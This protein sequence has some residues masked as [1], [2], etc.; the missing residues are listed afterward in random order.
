MYEL[1]VK[2]VQ[3]VG[4]GVA[5]SGVLVVMFFYFM[6]KTLKRHDD[7]VKVFTDT[8][9]AKDATLNNHLAHLTDVNLRIDTKV[10]QIAASFDKTTDRIILAM[11]KRDEIFLQI[12][13]Y[14]SP[15]KK[16]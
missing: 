7:D 16:E 4:L 11:E 9:R 12:L 13:G 3:E 6:R 2:A 8:I 15:E 1:F 14:K 5:M 10:D